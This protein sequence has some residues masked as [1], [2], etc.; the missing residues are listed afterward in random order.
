MPDIRVEHLSKSFSGTKVLDDVSFTVK[1]KEFV[2]LLGPS[3]C[4]KTTTLMCI[5]GFQ[6]PDQGLIACGDDIVRRPRRP[7]RPAG[8]AAQ[9]RDRVPVLR[10]LAAHDRRAER[11]VS[12]ARPQDGQARHPG[13]RRGGAGPGRARRAGRPLPAPAVRRPAAAGRAG[14]R[15]RALPG[16][17]AARRAVLQSRRQAAR[18]RPRLAQGAAARPRAHHGFRDPRPGRGAVDERPDP[19]HERRAHPAR[20]DAGGGLPAAPRAVRRRVRRPVQLPDRRRRHR[21][22][23]RRGPDDGGVQRRHR[24]PRASRRPERDHRRPAGGHRDQFRGP[25]RRA[26]SGNRS[27]RPARLLSRRPLPLPASRSERCS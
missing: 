14:P 10:D 23:R 9:P 6:T 17:A 24:R 15:H 13:S 3:G 2:T 16:G 22:G 5:A 11:G 12:A 19:G 25:A 1:D 4:G 27:Q 8:R 26:G 7:R 21:A 20:G 18:T